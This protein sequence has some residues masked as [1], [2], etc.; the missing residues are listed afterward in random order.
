MSSASQGL[1][2]SGSNPSD[3]NSPV[4]EA[5][6]R[7]CWCGELSPDDPLLQPCKC[8]GSVRFV[9]K[10]CNQQ[11]MSSSKRAY[12]EVSCKPCPVRVMLTDYLLF[13]ERAQG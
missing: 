13:S 2:Y 11:W 3:S 12:C 6:C 7:I 1:L 5:T 10:Q 9:H 4:E 8:S